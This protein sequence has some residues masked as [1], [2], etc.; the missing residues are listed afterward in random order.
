MAQQK[1]KYRSKITPWHLQKM[2]DEGKKISMMGTA[3]LDPLFILFAEQG[4]IPFC[5]YL[6]PGENSLECAEQIFTRTRQV[7]A[8]AQT[9]CLNAYMHSELYPDNSKALYNTARLAQDG[10]DSVLMMGITNEMLK[11]VTDNHGLVFG[12]V[13]L[14]SGWQT[15]RYGGY[16]KICKTA[17]ESMEVFRIAYEYQETGMIGMTIELVPRE[18]TNAIAAKLRVPIIQVA[19]S[20]AA[21]GSELVIFDVFE[22]TPKETMGIHARVYGNLPEFCIDAFRRF[23]EDVV[24]GSYPAE[25]NGWGMEPAEAEKLKNLIEQKY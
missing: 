20:G 24:S 13:G 23:D 6:A 11:Y 4:G 19:G 14:L 10:C 2:K 9:I 18:L 21:D 8:I 5:R 22:L 25:E 1:V 12:H 16:K 17:E 3:T 15:A 7:R